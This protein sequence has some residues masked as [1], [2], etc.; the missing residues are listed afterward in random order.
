VERFV[1]SD[2]R[3]IMKSILV[4][5]PYFQSLPKGI[6]MLLVTSENHYFG[7]ATAKAGDAVPR[8]RTALNVGASRFRGQSRLP[9]PWGN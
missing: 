7:E 4:S 2:K 5:Y 1:R 6:K 9:P 8:L 3:K